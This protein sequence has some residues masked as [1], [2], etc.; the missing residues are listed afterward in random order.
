M[1]ELKKSVRKFL[2]EYKLY[3]EPLSIEKIEEIIKKQGF[4]IVC[5]DTL[6]M[7]E[8]VKYLA[9]RLNLHDA[10]QSRDG[11]TYCQE[12][13]KL[14]FIKQTLS[15]KDKQSALLHEE[16]HI[17]LDH[18][19]RHGL[20][21][22]PIG[23]ENEIHDFI[24]LM[25]KEI[26]RKQTKERMR[27]IIPLAIACSLIIILVFRTRPSD[28]P[29][30]LIG[31]T[32]FTTAQAELPPPDTSEPD[33]TREPDTTSEQDSVSETTP[34]TAY[35]PVYDSKLAAEPSTYTYYWTNSGTVYHMYAD[36]Q[37]LKNSVSVQSGSKSLSGKERCCKTCYSRYL[38]ETYTSE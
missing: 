38:S 19:Y 15:E 23:H 21:E 28:V 8:K 27:V 24:H 36:C 4:E 25:N 6:N 31:S 10:C 22:T 32:I 34:V 12:N 20:R 7:S 16:I 30:H 13:I 35:V 3:D 37:H 17:Y 29:K 1:Q 14:V 11:F 9:D 33:T 2:T 5:F 26:K 18:P